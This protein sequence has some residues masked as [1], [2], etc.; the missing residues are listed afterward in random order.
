MVNGATPVTKNQELTKE[1]LKNFLPKGN[2]REI[3]DEIMKKISQF[4]EQGIEKNYGEEMLLTHLG[5]LKEVKVTTAEYIDAIKF[6]SLVMGGMSAH[7]AWEIVFPTKAKEIR[8]RNDG[9]LSTSWSTMYN[10]SK[11][12]TKLM[13]AMYVPA[14]LVYQP[15][16][17]WAINKQYEL[18]RGIGGNPDDRVSAHVQHLAAKEL[19]EM[20]KMPEDNTIHLRVGQS[21]EAK[22]ATARMTEQMAIIAKQQQDLIA[23]GRPIEDI[24]ALNLVH[25]GVEDDAIDVEVDGQDLDDSTK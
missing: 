23:Q 3:T 18:A 25:G 15:L 22:A 13:S 10:K 21:E 1:K 20:T 24:Q 9:K 8:D 4:E 12:V 19:Y 7:K 14:H 2:R 6:C 5:V 11:I 17:A 16:N